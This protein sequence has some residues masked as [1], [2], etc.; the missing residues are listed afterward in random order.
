MDNQNKT[1]RVAVYARVSTEHEAQVL[2]LSNQLEWYTDIIE[3]NPNYRE[4]ARYIDEG[5]TG[6][7]AKKRD[8][9]MRMIEDAK[10][11]K[12]DLVLTREISRFGR[13]T[14]E[15]L[16]Y[17]RLLLGWG[18]PVYFA[19]DNIRTDDKDGAMRL[20][21]LSAIAQDESRKISERV[22]FGIATARRNKVRYGNGNVLGYDRVETKVNTV[23]TVRFEINPEQAET[24]KMIFDWYLE[25]Y[26][27]RKIQFLLEQAGRLTAK[28]KT[29]WDCSNISRILQNRIYC[30][31]MEYGKQYSNSYLEQKRMNNYGENPKMVVDG[32]HEPIVSLETFEKVQA[33]MESHRKDIPN[34]R[35]GRKADGQK[36]KVDA[37]SKLLKCSCGHSF[38]RHKWAHKDAQTVYGYQCYSSV[39]TGSVQ[40]RINKGLSLDGICRS[41][42][43]PQWKLQMMAHY[44]FDNFI[45]NIDEVLKTANYLI[46]KHIAK[47]NEKKDNSRLIA[48]KEKETEKLKKRLTGLKNM[49]ADGDLTREEYLD[50][51]AEVEQE[52][53]NIEQTVAKLKAEQEPVEIIDYDERLK[54]LESA[55]EQFVKF[56]TENDIP[57]AVIE[58]FVEKIVVSED[59]YDWYLRFNPNN[60]D[61]KIS[62]KKTYDKILSSNYMH[63]SE[64]T[65]DI[66]YAKKF[67][68][69]RSTKHRVHKYNDARVN[70]FV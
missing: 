16:K 6:T 32:D 41:P 4:V 53:A 18:I 14:E 34:L 13:N 19:G 31:Q 47:E 37:W 24:V 51:K 58:A 7:S 63:I 43:I 66:D 45:S 48:S 50:S 29:N 49:R 57:D 65:L 11:G 59:S 27:V 44:V 1:I 38:N 28:G 46:E 35:T 54:M 9:F 61:V 2:A 64:A 23:K 68:Y 36:Q 62:G 8:G 70:I 12:F 26:G 3:R 52:I 55:L 10:Q 60:T 56:D 40:T 39:S 22:K 67:L 25:G 17:T 15:T 20:T 33:I 69:S 5:I 21:F 30:G 42:M